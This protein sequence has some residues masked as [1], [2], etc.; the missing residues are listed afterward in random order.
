M[1]VSVILF[2]LISPHLR[3]DGVQAAVTLLDAG[4]VALDPGVHQVE[5]L[6]IQAYYPR[7]RAWRAADKAGVFEDLQVLVDGLE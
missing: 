5:G 7:L 1:T 4:P 2:I 6:D 3:Q